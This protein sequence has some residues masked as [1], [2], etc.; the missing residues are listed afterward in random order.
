M[1]SGTCTLLAVLLLSFSAAA[2]AADYPTKP[3]RFLV[4]TAPGG[5]LDVIARFIMVPLSESLGKPV[6]VDNRGGASG[7]I[8]LETTAHAAPDGYTMII[9]SSSQ[10]IYAALNK[11]SYDL[12]RGFAPVSQISAAPYALVIYPG[13][14]INS[15]KELVAYA[16]ANREQ[17]NY[18]SSGNG[19]LQHLATEL[20]GSIVGVQFTHIP[21]K[22]IGAGFTDMIAGRTQMTMSSL[23]ALA[24][25]IR[26]KRMRALAVTGAERSA[27]LPEVPTMIEAGIPGFVVT[28]WHGTLMPAGTPRPVVERMQREIRKAVQRT[29]VAQRLSADGTIPIGSSPAEF[30]AHMKS[31]DVTWRKVIKQAGVQGGG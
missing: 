18:G 16:K 11:T 4:P 12:F 6:V 3:I 24:P 27:M 1:K 2:T 29:D 26:D 25:L 21:Y 13:L 31:E 5:G 9:F 23:S 8:A 7:A 17:L 19:T 22:G 15:V 14:P 10:I 28:Q 30:A 20:F